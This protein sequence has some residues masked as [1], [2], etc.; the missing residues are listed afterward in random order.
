MDLKKP[1]ARGEENVRSPICCIM[2][3]IDTGKTK[4][5]DYIIGRNV[6]EGEAGGTTQKI[7]A[8]YLSARNILEKTMEL[9]SDAKLNVPGL[10]FI[11]TPGY[12]FFM[13]LRSRGLSLCDFA[14]LVVDIMHGFEPQT[15]E[16]LN[17]L[18]KRNIEFIIAL[19]KVD[20]L[21]GW[22]TCENAPI[23]KAMKQQ[24]NDV[25]NEFNMRLNEIIDQ[26]KD[27]GI[28]TEL[29]YKN[30]E[31]RETFSIVP[32]SAISGEGIS[33]LLL[34]LV[35]L[36]QKTVVGKLTYVDKVQCI[37]LEVK[38]M[39]GY[40]TTIDVVLV[41]GELH[42]GDQIVVCGLQGPIVTT[43]RALLTPHP[44]KE[45]HV[46][47][48][49]VHHEVITAAQCINIIAQG[50][51]H[52]IVG[53]T[54]H[55]VGPDDD[56]E[57]I[58]ELVMED[59]ESILSRIDTSG[60][61]VYVQASTLGSLEAL[62]EFLK[63]PAVKLPVGGIGIGPVQKKDIMKAGVMLERKKEFATILALDVK[64]TT[65]ARELADEMGVKILCADIMY[66]LFD[67]FM[68]TYIV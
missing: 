21:Y 39:E 43:I 1:S 26:F 67:Q 55:V 47:G 32:T 36:S 60:E 54:L 65:E 33:D 52:A 38:V 6:Q 31:M 18:K 44:I 56:I 17:L 5:L 2:G 19:T 16:C 40:G 24:T 53:T 50:L 62:L 11:D 12:E 51:E 15:I 30:K 59:I 41:N 29:Y 4:M 37:V 63:S 57:A 22:K 64:V 14:I 3:H 9:K 28:N 34:L 66:H 68:H 7:G 10:L 49:H 27:Q 48:N 8:T 46:N 58:K 25:R 35:Q 13:N 23:M 42:E 61:G 20:R 45:L